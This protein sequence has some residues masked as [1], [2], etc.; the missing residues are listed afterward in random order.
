MQI[1][2]IL[3]EEANYWDISRLLDDRFKLDE[4]HSALLV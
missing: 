1:P 2:I 3:M 4:S